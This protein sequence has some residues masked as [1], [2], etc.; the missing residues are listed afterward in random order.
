MNKFYTCG[1]NLRVCA[2]SSILMCT[3]CGL[4]VCTCDHYEDNRLE[5]LYN[6]VC[7]CVCRPCISSVY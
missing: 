4:H 7:V 6:N 3:S 1:I 2:H 5:S